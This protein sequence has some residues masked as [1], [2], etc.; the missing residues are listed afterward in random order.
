M[1]WARRLFV[2]T[3]MMVTYHDRMINWPLAA[4]LVQRA[5]HHE[6]RRAVWPRLHQCHGM[7]ARI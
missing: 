3:V 1:I 6:P 2:R 5:W 4:G 7:H